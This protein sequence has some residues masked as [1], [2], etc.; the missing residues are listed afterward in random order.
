[1]SPLPPRIISAA[2]VVPASG[3]DSEHS[4]TV[5]VD[6]RKAVERRGVDAV[7]A[8][9]RALGHS[10]LEQASNNP[11]FDI[12]SQRQGETNLRIEVK[13]RIAGS[14]TFTITRT[15]V[16]LA[17]NAAPNHRL[18]LVSVHPDGA[19]FDEVR[20]IGDVFAG[21]EPSWLRDFGV[22]SQTFSWDHYW[23]LGRNPF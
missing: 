18:A 3:G 5:D 1:M 11:G 19:H 17:L 22:V 10:P 12:L 6:A 8:A 16:L 20:Y 9:E 14:D 2:L 23:D 15:E 21:A 7:L 13:A 4:P